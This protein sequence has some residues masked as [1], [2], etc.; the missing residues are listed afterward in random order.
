MRH[1]SLLLLAPVLCC[2]Q[3]FAQGPVITFDKLHHDF[4]KIPG[5]RKVSHRYKVTNTGKEPLQIKSLNPSCGCTSTVLGQWYLKP[6]ESTDVEITFNPQGYRG[7]VHKNLQVVSSDPANPTVTLTFEAEVV[8]EI[9]PSTTAVFIQDLPRSGVKTST[10]RLASGN[11]ESVHVTETKAPGAP[12]IA[13]AVRPEGKDAVVEIHV[14][15]RRVPASQMHGVD[16]LTIRTSNPRVPTIPVTIQWEIQASVAATPE[17][18]AWVEPAGKD[19]R[20]AVSLK[21]AAGKP[22]RITGSR[23]TNPLVRVEGVDGNAAPMHEF[24]ISLAGSARPGTYSERVVLTLDDPEQPEVEIR[25][26][27]VLR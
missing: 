7:P 9:M 4:G 15:G 17:R 18:V 2:A 3:A 5:D 24:R 23:T 12:Y 16:T 14:D 1:P 8:Q 20:A 6:G 11:G 19:L 21:Q 27:A 13:C 26:S 10:V 22:F 25:V